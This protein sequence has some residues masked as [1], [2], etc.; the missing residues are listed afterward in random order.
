MAPALQHTAT[1]NGDLLPI[2]EAGAAEERVG[3]RTRE[4]KENFVFEVRG[5]PDTRETNLM[6]E[7]E[8]LELSSHFLDV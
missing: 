2:K 6:A 4:K 5:A 1:E 7:N 3:E 8:D